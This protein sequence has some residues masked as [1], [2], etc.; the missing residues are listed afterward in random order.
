MAKFRACPECG[1]SLDPGEACDCTKSAPDEAD[2]S[3]RAKKYGT[4]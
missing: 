4:A 3:T 2:T 1:A